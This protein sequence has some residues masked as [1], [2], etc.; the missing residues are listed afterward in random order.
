MD[1][2]PP[3]AR[4]PCDCDGCMEQLAI[5]TGLCPEVPAEQREIQRA[6]DQDAQ[7]RRSI[8][9]PTPFRAVG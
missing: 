8:A 4:P 3:P 1:D 9:T 7:R 6:L 2:Q 5:L